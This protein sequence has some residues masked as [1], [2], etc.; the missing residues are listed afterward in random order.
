MFAEHTIESIVAL[1]CLDKGATDAEKDELQGLLLGRRRTR[2][3][4][5]YRDAAKRLG[6]SLPTV[7]RLVKDG[8]LKGIPGTGKRAC[9]ISEESLERYSA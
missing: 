3:V 2:A 1:A 6:L 7:K 8:R 9:G 5:K 4:V